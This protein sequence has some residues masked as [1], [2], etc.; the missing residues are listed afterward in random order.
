[1][2]IPEHVTRF[3][4]ALKPMLG[5]VADALAL[6]AATSVLRPGWLEAEARLRGVASAAQRFVTAAEDIPRSILPHRDCSDVHIS[7]VV[8]PMHAAAGELVE[9]LGVTA[10]VAIG[11]NAKRRDVTLHQITR[12]HL[13]SIAHWLA[14]FVEVTA[15]P[16]LILLSGN[17]EGDG[18]VSVQLE[19]K[20]STP[21][22]LAEL[23][24]W[25]PA[26]LA[27]RADHVRSVLRLMPES[28][29]VRRYEISLSQESQS[30]RPPDKGPSPWCGIGGGLFL[31]W[32]LGDCLS[33]D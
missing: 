32:L 7:K 13:V 33:D 11:P 8:Q 12:D 18:K 15:R 4:Q 30:P 26:G 27:Y 2:I 31:G 19:L 16:E 20:M 9:L 28:A 29:P 23:D 17:A 1:M 6:H 24:A 3:G 22:T 25:M 5:K 14:E 10:T 21:D